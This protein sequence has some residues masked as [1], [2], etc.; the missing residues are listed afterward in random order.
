MVQRG[1]SVTVI[2]D[3]T[4][5]PYTHEGVKVLSV[6]QQGMFQY[7]K[8]YAK[9]ADILITH[10]DVTS[11]AMLLALTLEKPLVHFVHNHNQLS[12]WGVDPRVPFKASLVVFN[13]HWIAEKEVLKVKGET[14]PWPGDQIILH[15]VVEPH[16]Y[17]CQKG[18]KVT[19]VNPTPGKGAETQHIIT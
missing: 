6:P 11:Q 19:L 12:Y 10:L 7:V 4:P 5:K 13:S 9:D 3:R 2:A 17:R 18:S 16:E 1:H 15:P 14:I 8:E